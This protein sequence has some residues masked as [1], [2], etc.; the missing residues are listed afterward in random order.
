M[1]NID[2]IAQR[3]SFGLIVIA[4]MISGLSGIL[5]KFM[6]IPTTSM[7]AIRCTTPVVII[8]L[9]LLSKK[10]S[11]LRQGW[12]TMIGASFLNAGRMFLF[13]TAYIYTTIGNAVIVMYTWPIFAA[14]MGAIFL[15]E[16]VNRKQLGL[17]A[18]SFVGII[19]VY[20]DQELSLANDDFIGITA[21]LFCALF[22]AITIIIFKSKN[23]DFSP[24]ETIV[25]QNIIAALIFLPFLATNVPTPTPLDWSL[26]LTHGISVGII[27]FLIFFYSLRYISATKASM[28]SYLE[29]ISALFFGYIFLGELL[30]T[31]MMIGGGIIVVS[32][33]LMK[34][35]KA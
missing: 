24:Q 14:I 32:T 10:K 19:I 13:F 28:I 3:H 7:V 18:L 23:K 34:L 5:I 4:A 1:I 6:S 22:Y 8:G 25:F 35:S 20:S 11:L 21:A 9:Y 12:K 15:K 17:L 27:M 31:S 2:Q 16:E 33:I 26:G 29:I 30:T